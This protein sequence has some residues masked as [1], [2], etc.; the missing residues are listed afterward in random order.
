MGTHVSD[1][2]YAAECHQCHPA[3]D[4]DYGH[5]VFPRYESSSLEAV[6]AWRGY[7][8]WATGHHPMVVVAFTRMTITNVELGPGWKALMGLG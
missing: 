8:R 1:E 2:G 6:E 3:V 7:H 5:L 4:V